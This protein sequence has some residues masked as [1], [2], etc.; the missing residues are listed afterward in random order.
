M[1]RHLTAEI[2]AQ[3]TGCLKISDGT[4]DMAHLQI[5]KPTIHEDNIIIL[6]Q[7]NC[8]PSRRA[9]CEGPGERR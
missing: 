5:H 7:G 6:I 1:L 3:F 9:H 2:T 8:P 4:T